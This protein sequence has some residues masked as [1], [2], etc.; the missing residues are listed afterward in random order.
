MTEAVR[1][2]PSICLASRSIA[3]LVVTPERPIYDWLCDLDEWMRNR[4]GFFAD[5]HVVLDLAEVTLSERAIAHVIN[6]LMERGV[7]VIA[8]AGADPPL[9]PSL[10]PV[11]RDETLAEEDDDPEP[12]LAE[13]EAVLPAPQPEPKAEPPSLLMDHPIRSGQSV[14][15]PEGDVIVLGSIG[16]GAEV[17][18]GGSLHV[19]GTL[20]GRAAAGS[21]GNTNA[22]IF[23]SRNEAEILSIAGRYRIADTLD[24]V[25]GRPVQ[26]WLD[27]G[28]VRVAVLEEEA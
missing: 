19:Y 8:L 27:D 4:P 15:F 17:I 18:A 10:P 28:E 13:T 25:W 2:Q 20:R 26:A 24:D 7:H 21:Q 5:R 12:A 3:A 23:C 9:G 14:I 1:S 11:V 6:E 22:R 16:S